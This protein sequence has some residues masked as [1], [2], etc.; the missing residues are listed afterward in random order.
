VS[1]IRG[2]GLHGRYPGRAIARYWVWLWTEREWW[3][4]RPLPVEY[5]TCIYT[6]LP[7]AGKT[8]FGTDMVCRLL[9]DG[10]RVYSNIQMKDPFTGRAALPIHNWL[11][12]LRA[13][14]E[15]LEVGE[16]SVIY[17]AEINTLCDARDW[18][19]TP[20]WWTEFMQMRRHMGLG[21]MGDT[22]ALS[23]LEKRLRMLVAKVIAVRPSWLRTIWRRWPVFV[24]QEINVNTGDDPAL[25]L[26]EGKP[27]RW[28]MYSH[29]FHGHAT[30]ELVAAQSFEDLSSPAAQEEIERLRLRAIELNQRGVIPAFNYDCGAQTMGEWQEEE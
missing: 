9:R 17:L 1:L 24:A 27:H 22:Q 23:Q 30:W 4:I 15:A 19:Y 14:I 29:A 7:G 20:R 28:W 16:T 2:S 5:E 26:P 3:F 8:T 18:Q 11:D 21:L 25:W 13:S 12:V 10:V 6:G